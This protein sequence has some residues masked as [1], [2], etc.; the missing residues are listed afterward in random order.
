MSTIERAYPWRGVA[1]LVAAALF[2][3]NL[4]GTILAT[5][6]PRMAQSLGVRPLDLNLAIA[7]YL[8]TV[9]VFIPAS[10][11]IA[12]RFGARPVFACALGLFTLASA[13]C[14]ASDS[15]TELT[16]MRVLQG[17]G[18]AMTVPVGRLVVLRSSQRTDLIAAIA[19]L[20]WPA[21]VAPIAAPALGGMF[22]TY[23]S[24]RWI[25]LINVPFGVVALI[26]AL[27][28]IPDLRPTTG[29][30][31]DWR[32]FALSGSGIA[33]LL[34]S[35]ELV[36]ATTIRWA[37][38]AGLAACGLSLIVAAL[39]HVRRAP[40]PLLDLNVM[41]IATFR[42]SNL[43]GSFFRVAIM[44]VP[45]LLPLM[46]Q[47]EFGWSPVK[48]GV[49]VMAVFI[50]NLVIKPFTTMILRRYGFRTVLVMNGAAA[51]ASVALC[52]AL[53]ASTPV[54]IVM[55]VLFFS[56][57]FRSIGFTAYN[58]IA[59]VD[60]TPEDTA[61]AN[62]LAST[63]QQVSAG[64]G[65]AVGA[66]ALRFGGGLGH[67]VGTPGRQPFPSAF[68][69]VAAIALATVAD[70]IRLPAAAGSALTTARA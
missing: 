60:V 28:I 15:L 6:A 8:L 12:D 58:T 39:R 69:I 4:D 26:G 41:R 10:G 34:C 64:L 2:M 38:P 11:W 9:G 49:V 16:V 53:S 56:G 36:T 29:R 5:A 63:V 70:A 33:S 30:P 40:F 3:E 44:A 20:T 52:G 32:G 55:L 59:F 45:F 23:A 65:V 37:L 62:T 47:D 42:I 35:L 21:L 17:I 46:F 48:A 51:A 68:A 50:G 67:L 14:A 7:T 61:D 31:L 1:L 57:V 24:W 54:A 18:G 19:Y 13:L 43:G 66:L 22:A 27:R 25:F